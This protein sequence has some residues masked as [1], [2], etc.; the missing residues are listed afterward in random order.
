MKGHYIGP[1]RSGSALVAWLLAVIVAGAPVRAQSINYDISAVSLSH[2]IASNGA[3]TVLRELLAN[4]QAWNATLLNMDSGDQAWLEVASLLARAARSLPGETDPPPFDMIQM[5]VGEA[6]QWSPGNVL[7]MD[8]KVFALRELCGVKGLYNW[9]LLTRDLALT[10]VDRR[11]QAL[12]AVEEPGLADARSQC[13]DFLIKAKLAISAA[14][15]NRV[16]P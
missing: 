16:D 15:T 13:L 9:R 11:V 10:A 2:R 3:E 14:M 12:S 5:A 7:A 4:Q 1:W 6:L 8:E